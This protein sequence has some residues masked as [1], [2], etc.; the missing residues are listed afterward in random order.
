LLPIPVSVEAGGAPFTLTPA[1]RVAVPAGRPEAARA[2][3][4]LAGVLRRSTGFPLPV[5][6]AG[7]GQ[8]GGTGAV[9]FALGGDGLAGLGGEG[10]ELD[11]RADGVTVRANEPEGLFRGAQ[12]LRQLLP[13][14]VE[15]DTVQAGV[16][17]QVPGGRVADRPRF[18]WRG[19]MLDVARHF[20]PVADVKRYVD[21]MALYKLNVLHLHLT[22]D[23]GWRI[24]IE[25][26]P[27]LTS[28][29]GSTAVGGG[30]GGFYTGRDY[31]DIVRYARDR[32]VTVVPE[33][34]MPGHTTAALSSYA[35]LS[36]DHTA[37]AL[38]TG[39]GV[40]V[41]ALCVDAERT[42]EFV[43]QVLGQLAAM[44]PGPYLHVGGDEAR[45]LTAEPYAR[46]VERAQR[47]VQ[48]HGK[49]MVAWQ[50]AAAAALAPTSV[51]QYWNTLADTTEIRAVAGRGVKLVLSPASKVYLDMKYDAGTGLGLDWAG[52]V[53]V[54][55]AYDWD[56]AGLLE[57]VTDA[58]VL[59][60]EAP[61]WTETVATFDDLQRMAYPRLQGLA[62]IGWSPRDRR[63]WAGYRTRLAAQAP[64]WSA[65][66]VRYH[67]S[68][69]VPWPD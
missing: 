41:S 24:E 7:A 16:S 27:R 9:T 62:E 60:V 14:A 63:S 23:Q 6:P 45:T 40:W 21:V 28:H 35:E 34:D 31:A 30:P 58:E 39:V 57:G 8:A 37:P 66:G 26:W 33:V 29:G 36:C 59:G 11:V 56:P 12:T 2:A 65:M 43:D 47:I 3:E 46:F 15:R 53:E 52:T 38:Y 54:D 10:Y 22:D 20:F 44:T 55:D 18:A 19:A 32:Y 1:T 64:R 68:P 48:A 25:G 51:A 13:A 4:L 67:R 42:Y 49:R 17:W 50:E 61:L 69:R 5:G